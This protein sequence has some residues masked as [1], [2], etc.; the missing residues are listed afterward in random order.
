[1]HTDLEGGCGVRLSCVVDRI[2]TAGREIQHMASID[3]IAAR[4]PPGRFWRLPETA[5]VVSSNERAILDLVR[6]Q[7]APSRADLVRATGLTAQS[8]MRLVDEL[9]SRGLVQLGDA[10]PRGGRG[11]PSPAVE[12]VPEFA[13]AIG[14]SIT[15]DSV[16]TA[17]VDMT[18]QV[19]M[20]KHEA[21]SALDPSQLVKLVRRHIELYRRARQLDAE[22][23]FGIGV[24]VTGFFVGEG[25]RVNPP[26]PLEALALVDLEDLLS[27]ELQQPVWLD[28][29]GTVAANGE[30]LLGVGRWASNFLYLYFSHGLGGG[31]VVDGRCIRGAHGNAGEAAGMLP[32]Q[33]MERPTL[34]QLRLMLAEDGLHFV[35][36]RAML[37]DFRPHWAACGRWIERARPAL[38]LIVS[39]G[40][41]LLDPE[42]VV[43]GGRLPRSLA[44]RLIAELHVDNLPRRDRRRPEPRLV[45]AEAP[46]D[47]TAIGAA[48]LPFKTCLFS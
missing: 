35:D 43:F 27:R 19:L 47:S 32:L 11:K 10:V 29:D 22:K 14:V 44:E 25:A 23:L 28:N 36:I 9:A 24:G 4:T 7:G 45:P 34:E 26:A 39:A 5:E 20:Q 21:V 30:S 33:N 2:S 18:G 8:V 41:A 15:T 1:M 31:V 40:F 17:V 13:H 6:R 46:P 48:L 38:S 16:S 12:L 42:A 37:E 3:Q